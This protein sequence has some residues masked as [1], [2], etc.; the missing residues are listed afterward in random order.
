MVDLDLPELVCQRIRRIE[1]E[2]LEELFAR[3]RKLRRCFPLQADA[4]KTFRRHAYD[5]APERRF[6]RWM[7]RNCAGVPPQN[8]V[9]ADARRSSAARFI[10][11]ACFMRPCSRR[12]TKHRDHYTGRTRNRKKRLV[13]RCRWEVVMPQLGSASASKRRK[14]TRWNQPRTMSL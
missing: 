5:A 14:R 8:K 1:D 4:T 2:V 10:P 7:N 6:S 3:S 11:S 12:T 13:Q 9:F